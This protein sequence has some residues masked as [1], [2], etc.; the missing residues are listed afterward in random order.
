MTWV[1]IVFGHGNSSKRATG[2]KLGAFH[3]LC[4]NFFLLGRLLGGGRNS[5]FGRGGRFDSRLAP[6]LLLDLM[7]M[8][9]GRRQYFWKIFR[10]N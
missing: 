10:K 8:S 6:W 1:S 7:I 9:P 4:L 2:V 3:L 5:R